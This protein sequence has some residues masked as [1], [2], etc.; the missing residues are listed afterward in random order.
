M[1]HVIPR[2]DCPKQGEIVTKEVVNQKNVK[3]TFPVEI[4]QLVDILLNSF[5]RW[6]QGVRL[7]GLVMAEVVIRIVG[8]AK[9]I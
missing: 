4:D 9:D 6:C 3:V 5:A 7:N 8:V 2:G 1:D